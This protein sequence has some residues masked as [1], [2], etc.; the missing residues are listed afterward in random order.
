M[1]I[2]AVRK[3][4]EDYLEAILMIQKEKGSCRSIDIVHHLGVSKPS[5]S[6][7]MG[8][9]RED[10]MITTNEDG[11]MSFTESGF[12]LA[13]DIYARHCLLTDFLTSIGV[14]EDVAKEDACK[15][16]HDI[17]KETFECL[18]KHIAAKETSDPR[19]DSNG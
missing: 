8:I 9:L 3:S 12:K 14:P 2:L 18:K 15:I 4:G 11:Y 13:T 5:V 19:P 17:S 7:A 10:G 1:I 6:V 16:E